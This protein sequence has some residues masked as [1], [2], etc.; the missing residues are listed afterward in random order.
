MMKQCPKCGSAE[1][2]P[3]LIVFAPGTKMG[4][5]PIFVALVEPEPPNRP[6]VWKPQTITTGFRAAV[7]GECGHSELYTK[8]YAE[9]T[10]AHK[11]GFKTK[12]SP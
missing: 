7:C 4:D 11:K 2:I 9:M 8:Q 5:Q 12:P 1:I 3:D 10:S 6:F